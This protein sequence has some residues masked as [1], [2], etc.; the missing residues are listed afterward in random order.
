[1][2]VRYDGRFIGRSANGGGVVHVRF[3][4]EPDGKITIGEVVE[5]PDERLYAAR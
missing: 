3:Y 2:R 1:M 5:S 4:I